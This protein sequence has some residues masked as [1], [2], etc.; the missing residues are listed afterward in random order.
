MQNPKPIES[1]QLSRAEEIVEMNIDEFKNCLAK[2]F[3]RLRGIINSG[4]LTSQ[5]S[6][7]I[8]E[9]HLENLVKLNM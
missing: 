4:E 7:G 3:D 2:E 6:T 5:K 8:D 9:Q 1:V